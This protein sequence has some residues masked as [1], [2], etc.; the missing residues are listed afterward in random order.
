MGAGSCY[1]FVSYEVSDDNGILM[2]INK[3]NNSMVVI[4]IFNTLVYKNANS[5][6]RCGM[7][8]AA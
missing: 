5:A 3:H 7:K 6:T 1:P 8:S 2:G 4:D